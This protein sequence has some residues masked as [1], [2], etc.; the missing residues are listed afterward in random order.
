ML[1]G[2]STGATV[3]RKGGV[4]VEVSNN[5]NDDFLYN[6]FR[7]LAEERVTLAVKQPKAFGKIIL[8]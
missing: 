4:R 5:V 1:I 6:R 3:Y 7:T 8:K 2:N